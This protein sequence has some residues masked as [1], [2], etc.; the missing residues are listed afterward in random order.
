MAF[1]KTKSN[2]PD[3]G[4]NEAPT[5][6]G[7]EWTA[8]RGLGQKLTT[9]LL[10]VAVACGP[11]ALM[12][13]LLTPPPAPAVA[14]VEV[15]GRLTSVQQTAGEYGVAFVGAWLSATRDQPGELS[16]YISSSAIRQLSAEPWLYR[17]LSL[18]S[19]EPVEGSE[20]ISV[21][22][23]ATV[24]EYEAETDSGEKIWPR[25]YFA[26]TVRVSDE[27]M[28]IIGLPAPVAAPSHESSPIRL[29]YTQ[30][31]VSSSSARATVEAFLAAY[32]LGTGE[33]ARYVSPGSE[34]APITPTPYLNLTI[35]DVKSDV[36]PS[37]NPATGSVLHV[38]AVAE[39]QS[40]AGQQLTTTYALTFTARDGRW[41][42]T[43]VDLAPLESVTPGAASA[44]T[45]S[46]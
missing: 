14:A 41:E 42:T 15:D 31:V 45:T 4:G 27:G 13:F 38:L 22:A 40:N 46:P 9:G 32:L 43:S 17:D 28:S 35:T 10:L 20:L 16:R 7:S 37:D 36:D 3:K 18:V 33:I 30:T 8:G 6:K 34:I 39:V 21:V 12:N 11:L 5:A 19:I 2:K 29:A 25:R 44:N 26:V 1:K 23:A 24:E